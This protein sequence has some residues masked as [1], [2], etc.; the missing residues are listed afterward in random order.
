MVRSAS[1][2]RSMKRLRLDCATRCRMTSVSV[3]DCIIAPPRTRSRR[4][5]SPLVR[6]PLCA[7]P[8]PAGV[9]FGK[10]RLHVAQYG[11]AGR[12]I[13]DMADRGI[14]GQPLDHLAAGK[15]VPDKAKSPLGMKA[16][17]VE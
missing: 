12:G 3:V 5:V 6:F 7:T 15:G 11:F 14:A 13:A 16:G 10:Q 8:N 4:R 1:M 2:K 17:S 9:E